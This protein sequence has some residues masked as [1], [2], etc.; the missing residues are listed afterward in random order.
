MFTQFKTKTLIGIA[1][2]S[3]AC[4]VLSPYIASFVGAIADSILA[5]IWAESL[6]P[7]TVWDL[8]TIGEYAYGAVLGVVALGSVS[9]G[10]RALYILYRRYR[11]VT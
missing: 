3:I 1:V 5:S 9:L 6:N 8:M 2:A 7:V 10:S 11:N 4:L